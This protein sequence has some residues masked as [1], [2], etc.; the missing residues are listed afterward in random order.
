VCRLSRHIAW[1]SYMVERVR[2][3]SEVRRVEYYGLHTVC[4]LGGAY[5]TLPLA[6][7][8]MFEAGE[9]L[10]RSVGNEH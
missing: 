4:H 3:R 6:R 10:I 7:L 2:F 5:R 9:A 8:R 1:R